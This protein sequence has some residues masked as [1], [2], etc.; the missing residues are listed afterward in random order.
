MISMADTMPELV[1]VAE[2]DP[3]AAR[4]ARRLAGAGVLTRLY[5][6]IYTSNVDSPPESIVLRH[7]QAIVGHLLPGGVIS[8]RSAFDSRPL[9]GS[10][11]VTRGKTRRD[12]RLPG[13]TVHIVPGPGPRLEPPAP[14]SRFGELYLASDPRRFLENLTRGRG[15]NARVLPQST[16]EAALDRIL[17]VGGPKRLNQ[18]RDQAR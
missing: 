8:H 4:R 15:W 5:P 6:S 11:T 2:T 16:I 1:L 14:D 9:E 10:L 18:L 13:L 3:A 12:L 7:W 17:M